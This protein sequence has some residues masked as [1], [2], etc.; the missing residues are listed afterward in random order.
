MKKILIGFMLIVASNMVYGQLHPGMQ[1][2][3]SYG[4][5]VINTIQQKSYSS[6]SILAD[7]T[8]P[9]FTSFSLNTAQLNAMHFVLN[10]YRHAAGDTYFMVMTQ[11]TRLGG[12]WRP[13]YLIVIV[14][15]YSSS[16]NFTYWSLVDGKL[17]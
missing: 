14:I 16:N 7:F 1:D 3:S 15:E 6:R 12:T 10:K 11:G 13:F 9:P 5:I 2:D 8:N 4:D 17:F